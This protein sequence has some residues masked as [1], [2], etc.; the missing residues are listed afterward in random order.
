MTGQDVE[1]RASDGG[2]F[3]AYVT[4]PP[5]PPGP[6]IVLLQEIFG[7]N[8]SMRRHADE[9]AAAGFA[10]VVPDL[11]WR[12]QPNVQLDPG[13]PGDRDAAMKLL[14]GLDQELAVGDAAAAL[15]YLR[16]S[17]LCTGKVAALGFC[18]GGR[19]AF[20][21]ALSTDIDGSVSF[22]GTGLDK[23][24]SEAGRVRKPVLL[25]IAEQD[26]VCPPDAQRAI[27]HGIAPFAT[28]ITAH[29]YAGAGHAFARLGG[30]DYK[31]DAADLAWKRTRE[32]LKRL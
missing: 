4:M 22:Y 32:F 28:L 15:R 6:G 19:L 24:V 18:L 3:T 5:E 1:L 2:S 13:K 16:A 10:V 29:T 21:M 12:Q 27:L 8:A 31:A 26:R 20:L 30:A 17:P 11:F 25:H 23:I 9:L 14:Q 7:V